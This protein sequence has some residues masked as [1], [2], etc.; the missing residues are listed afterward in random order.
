MLAVLLA[1]GAGVVAVALAAAGRIFAK[2]PYTGPTFTVRKEKIKISIVSRGSLE[3]VKNGDIV[4]YV[5]AGTKGSTN[6]TTIK[7]LVDAGTEV[8]KGDKL[9]E[10]DSSGLQTQLDEQS[11]KVEQA[12][13]AK[14]QADEGYLIQEI[15]NETDIEKAKNALDLAK[16]DLEKYK[17]GDY[18]QALL[19]VEGRIETA[20]SDL[21]NWSD[22]AKWSERMLKKNLMSKVQ[23]DA[24]QSRVD[25]ARI[26]LGMIQEEKRVLTKYMQQRT[27]QDLAAKLAEAQ[28]GVA[29]AKG[30]ARSKLAQADA[31]RLEKSSIYKREAAKKAEIEAEIAKCLIVAPQDGLVVYYIPPQ[32]RGG[33]GGTQ[34]SII[35]QGEPVREGQKLMQ[36]PDLAHMLVNVKI[37]EAFISHVHSEDPDDPS[38]WQHATIRIDAFPNRIYQGHIKT[39]DNVAQAADFF[40]S[41]VKS[42]KTMIA[43]DDKN[44]EGLKPDMSAEVSIFA[45]ESP[46]EVLVVPVQAVVGT[47]NM[48]AQ[49]KVFVVG[50]NG[51]PVLRDIVVGMSNERLVEVKSGLEVGERVVE[52]PR[53]LLSE[54]S[55]LKPGKVR[56][57]SES[58]SHGS[59]GGEGGKKGRKGGKKGA[60]PSGPGG[61]KGAGGPPGMGGPPTAEQQQAMRQQVLER[62]RGMSPAERRGLVNQIPEAYR[63]QVQQLLRDNKLEVAE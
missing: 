5:R 36:I 39:V 40:S 25:G 16:I 49:R 37:P 18:Q 4:C 12:K 3:S 10:L 38:T 20:K 32:V 30:Q 33:G 22:R 9:I 34:Q 47:I 14:V 44:V 13:A 51:Q 41:D 57:K 15:D 19:G 29:K 56:T 21:E 46:T 24:D 43:I 52:N 61:F 45:D 11:I 26:S 7:W 62:A 6:S 48:G 42:Y 59:G 55:E 2:A 27:I 63:G 28:R 8:K 31:S 53:P 60:P 58:D 23:A 50:A 54:D 17:E 35:A 1:L